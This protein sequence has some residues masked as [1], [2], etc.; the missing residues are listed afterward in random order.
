[1][2]PEQQ[3]EKE[4]ATIATVIC[5][6][7]NLGMDRQIWVELGA[8]AGLKYNIAG[9]TKTIEKKDERIKELEEVLEN[10]N[11]VL[12]SIVDDLPKQGLGLIFVK[13]Q[14]GSNDKYLTN[15]Q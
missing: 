11:Q 5:Q 10:N 4:A 9:R 2:T 8:L 7:H 14:I 6:E 1:M 13:Q 15:K 12:K 3:I